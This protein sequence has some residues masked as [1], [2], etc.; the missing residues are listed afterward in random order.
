MSSGEKCWMVQGRAVSLETPV[1][2][3]ILNVTPD[4][5]SDGG[6]YT[7]VE[8]AIARAHEIFNQGAT[9]VDVGGES[10]RPG[11]KSVSTQEQIRRVVPVIEGIKGGLISID[12]TNSSV[13]AAAIDAGA[14]IINDVS[15]C[16]DDPE[17]L[18]LAAECGVGL[19]LMHRLVSPL[20]DQYSDQYKIEPNYDDVVNEVLA[21]LLDRVEIARSQGVRK[22]SIAIDPGLGFGKSVEQ[23]I[24][25][26][27]GIGAFVETGY[28]VFIGASRKSFI[29]SIS[30]ISEAC[31]RDEASACMA[32]EMWA[33]GAQVFRV[34][35]VRTH[36]RMLQS[37]VH[38]QGNND[39]R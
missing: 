23:N 38:G 32:A 36:V 33:K 30:G 27:H 31:E 8:E 4:S 7:S 29:G 24:A 10:T 16:Q 1:L 28:P 14:V 21:W 2:V 17:M 13:A 11:A 26:M 34:H 22:E 20:V 18:H 3:G 37:P 35:D 6:K 19:V 25:L 12:T 9:I 15:A 5:F 39:R